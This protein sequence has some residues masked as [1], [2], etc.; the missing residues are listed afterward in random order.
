MIIEK[1]IL[2]NNSITAAWQIL[3]IEFAHASRWASAVNHSEA[4]GG[5]FGE[6]SCEERGCETSLG[7]ISEQLI[8]FSSKDYSLSYKVS[9]GMPSFVKFAS[10]TWTLEPVNEKSCKLKIIILIQTSGIS[11]KLMTPLLYLQMAKIGNELLEDF[12]WY[13]EKGVPHARKLKTLKKAEKHEK[14]TN[15]AVR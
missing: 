6:S 1:E 13:V 9:A 12:A 7:R 5:Q 4:K 15:L 2:V 10:N 8:S 3:G 14:A 11:G